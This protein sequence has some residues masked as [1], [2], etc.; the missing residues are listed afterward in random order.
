MGLTQ[1]IGKY[2]E[3]AAAEYLRRKGY[4][5]LSQNYRCKFG[6]VDIIALSPDKCTVFVEVKTRQNTDYGYPS[7][8][9]NY[10]KQNKLRKTALCYTR[11]DQIYMR[12]DIVEVLYKI[13]NNK[14]M[15][16]GVKHIENAF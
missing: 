8:F 15:V 12:F 6:E 10:Q 2:G 1:R 14:I 3:S 13:E 9:V 7:Q 5:I 4:L 11:T 16:A